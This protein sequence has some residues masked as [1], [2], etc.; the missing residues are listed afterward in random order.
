MTNRVVVVTGTN[1]GI[2]LGITRELG[3]RGD[4]VIAGSRDLQ[5]GQKAVA[6]LQGDIHPHQLDITDPDSI[7]RLAKELTDTYGRVDAL[8]N[9]AAI[10]YD[11]WQ[12]ARDA[13][14][15]VVH[16]AMETNL[17]GAWR[18]ILA[19]LPLIRKS[20]HPRIVNVSSEAASLTSYMG[21]G[22][23]AYNTSKA[24]LDALTI[25]LAAELRGE[26]ILVNAICPGWVAT[27]MGGPGGVPVE[28]GAERVIWGIDLP[29]NG[30]TGGFF[31]DGKRLSW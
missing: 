24:A 9:S 1:R 11:T 3:R 20:E 8:I 21:G 25:T 7:K 16:E 14:L 2:G 6:K 31:R 22:T 17:F 4:T 18:M 30:P 15:N 10:H 27:D 13:D 29:D 5:K 26:R 12:S 23:P 28:K 19:L